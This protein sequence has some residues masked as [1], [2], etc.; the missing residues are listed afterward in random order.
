MVYFLLH[1]LDL[2]LLDWSKQDVICIALESS[3]Y[4][5]NASKGDVQ[6]LCD[7]ESSYVTSLQWNL[8]GKYLAVGTN[9]ADVQV[10]R[11]T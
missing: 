6:Q 3:V 2:N 9:D 8:S 10:N 4:V 7:L 11:T 1:G 5:F